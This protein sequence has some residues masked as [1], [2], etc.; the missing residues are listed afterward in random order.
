M[1]QAQKPNCSP[2]DMVLIRPQAT[3]VFQKSSLSLTQ[4]TLLK[5]F[6][7][8]CPILTKSIHHL[9]SKNFELSSHVIRRIQSNF[10]SALAVAIGHFTKLLIRKQNLSIPLLSSLA[11]CHGILAK[12]VNVMTLSTSG[13]WLSKHQTSRGNISLIFLTVT[14]S[15]NCLTSKAGPG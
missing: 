6:S 3:M 13:I 14:I 15:L 8:L 2:S 7:I 4:S 9:S 1:S 10:G 12:K 5:R 11:K